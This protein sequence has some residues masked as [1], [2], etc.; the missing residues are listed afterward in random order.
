MG[1]VVGLTERQGGGEGGL[2]VYDVKGGWWVAGD[3]VGE[4]G[5]GQRGSTPRVIKKGVGLDLFWAWGN[6]MD[7]VMGGFVCGIGLFGFF[8]NN[9]SIWFV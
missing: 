6:N 9:R 2:Q 3:E 1:F 7:Q 5:G 4:D 8:I